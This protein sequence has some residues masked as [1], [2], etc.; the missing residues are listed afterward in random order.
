MALHELATNAAKHGALSVAGGRVALDW[1]LTG[2]RFV[3]RWV[4]SGGPRVKE[5]SRVGFGAT[6]LG[7]A[8][9]GVGGTT[10]LE[11]RRDGLV[12]EMEAPVGSGTD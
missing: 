3:L 4:E 6:V 12:C 9:S 10:R 11:W 8:L 2:E 7:R 1:R 5:P